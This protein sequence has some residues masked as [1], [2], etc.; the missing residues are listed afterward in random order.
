MTPQDHFHRAE[1]WRKQRGALTPQETLEHY[2]QAGVAD[3]PV[4]LLLAVH[5]G[6]MEFLTAG[7]PALAPLISPTL[8][9]ELDLFVKRGLFDLS[10]FFQMLAGQPDWREHCLERLLA[11]HLDLVLQALVSLSPYQFP[12]DLALLL[13]RRASQACA[14]R[15][16]LAQLLTATCA[17][18]LVRRL[19]AV[20]S[21]AADAL[22]AC[23]LPESDKCALACKLLAAIPEQDH[24]RPAR[25]TLLACLQTDL[26]SKAEFEQLLQRESAFVHGPPLR[27][28]VAEQARKLINMGGL[29]QLAGTL[30]ETMCRRHPEGGVFSAVATWTSEGIYDAVTKANLPPDREQAFWRT[31]L[32]SAL[33]VVPRQVAVRAIE[34]QLDLVA[35]SNQYLPALELLAQYAGQA[36]LMTAQEQFAMA[37]RLA[38]K[39]KQRFGVTLPYL[40]LVRAIGKRLGF[41]V[42]ADLCA[43]IPLTAENR[44]S[45][46]SLLGDMLGRAKKRADKTALLTLTHS[47]R[48]ELEVFPEE[49]WTEPEL[50]RVEELR[51]E[52]PTI[53]ETVVITHYVAQGRPLE[54]NP[55][56][57]EARAR[58]WLKWIGITLSAIPVALLLLALVFYSFTLRLLGYAFVQVEDQKSYVT[59]WYATD[60]APAL[61][62]RLVDD[63][64]GCVF[65]TA[66]LEGCDRRL[67]ISGVRDSCPLA[68][69]DWEAWVMSAL[70]RGQHRL[71]YKLEGR[72]ADGATAYANP[73]E[74]PIEFGRLMRLQPREA[75]LCGPGALPR[76]EVVLPGAYPAGRVEFYCQDPQASQPLLLERYGFPDETSSLE[77][78][79]SPDDWKAVCE[80]FQRAQ[81]FRVQWWAEV[82]V[83]NLAEPVIN[84]RRD[85]WSLRFIPATLTVDWQTDGNG[86]VQQFSWKDNLAEIH[87][88]TEELP[89]RLIPKVQLLAK[90]PQG[91]RQVLADLSS[92]G[93]AVMDRYVFPATGVGSL[94]EIAGQFK[95]EVLQLELCSSAPGVFAVT[96]ESPVMTMPKR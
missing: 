66:K 80:Q 19:P 85:N 21:G 87:Q 51:E 38:Q 70:Q 12:I 31:Y 6:R 57:E 82:Y 95:T 24:T 62:W 40:E 39:A 47:I 16:W 7:G 23:E 90:T 53:E 5:Y 56:E 48:Q 45:W 22:L 2:A 37:R 3:A 26:P 14:A 4:N 25:Q 76:F 58:K 63:G 74:I 27:S 65:H 20:L 69:G 50:F 15:G 10:R 28:W 1:N 9:E 52:L 79:V 49:D 96:A 84:A 33:R 75:A 34:R 46:I 81:S 59:A 68:P 30:L 88:Q 36:G 64:T 35:D 41:E 43:K 55:E 67:A 83:L 78:Q 77:L 94:A 42:A 11:R 89:E 29:E 17:C 13:L 92:T 91:R 44:T 32:P 73:I 71:T 18:G 8:D 72:C 60:P 93:E 54:I 86:W 61:A